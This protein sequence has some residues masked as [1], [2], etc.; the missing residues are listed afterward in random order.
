MI[1]VVGF[2]LAL[3]MAPLA[4]A[5]VITSNAGDDC[6]DLTGGVSYSCV[7]IT[8]HAVWQPNDPL[9]EGAEWISFTSSGVE[10]GAVYLTS[11]L[12]ALMRVTEEVMVG[13]GGA[14]LTLT[15]WADDT[16]DV[17]VNSVNVFPANFTMDSACSGP[18]PIACEHDEGGTIQMVLAEGLNTIEIEAYQLG[19]GPFGVLYSGTLKPVP[20][21]AA[22]GFLGLGLVGIGAARRRRR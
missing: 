8:P 16:A 3:A 6:K 5:G 9:G 2:V 12:D 19:G 15:V 17:F 1:A 20:E 10:Q 11:S 4:N 7:A 14:I 21:P 13:P 22:L 18:D